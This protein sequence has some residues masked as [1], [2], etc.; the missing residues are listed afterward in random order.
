MKTIIVV[1]KKHGTKEILVDDEYYVD[2]SKYKWYLKKG[3]HTFYVRREVV[4][5]G[6]KHTIWMHRHVMGIANHDIQVDH[7]DGNGLNNQRS[8]LRP[9]TQEQNRYNREV[10]KNTK[11]TY[12]GLSLI[13][14][15]YWI[16]KVSYKGNRTYLGC[17]LTPEDAAMAYD[18]AAKEL[19]G[20]FA[21]LNFN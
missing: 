2:A 3:R 18:K 14:G 13:R 20:E 21:K 4:L 10:N 19:H 15:K 6:K 17:Y 16:A 12:K 5:N 7:K 8:N 9:C 1:S 11:S